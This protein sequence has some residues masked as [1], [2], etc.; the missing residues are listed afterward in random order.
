MDKT[1]EYIK[2]ADLLLFVLEKA[3]K[4]FGKNSLYRLGNYVAYTEVMDFLLEEEPEEFQ[5]LALEYVQ[6]D[7]ETAWNLRAVIL[8]YFVNKS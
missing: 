5:K 7:E 4:S 2:N 6:S 8:E 1:K 3:R